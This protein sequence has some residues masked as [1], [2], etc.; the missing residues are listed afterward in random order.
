MKRKIFTLI[1]L[2]IRKICKKNITQRISLN[3]NSEFCPDANVFQ[4]L[5]ERVPHHDFVSNAK[6]CRN[7]RLGT[8][9]PRRRN[10]SLCL[11]SFFFLRLFKCFP[12]RLFDCFP[13]P[14]SFRVS[15]SIFLLRRVKIR[16]F[17]LIELL[18]VI[19]IIAILAAMLLPA[20]N[21]AKKKAQMIQCTSNLK[22]IGTTALAYT[23][24]YR[25]WLITVNGNAQYY[26][27]VFLR[28]ASWPI[29]LW[30]YRNHT[31]LPNASVKG[32][33]AFT[34]FTCPSSSSYWQTG[35]GWSSVNYALNMQCGIKWGSGLWGAVGLKL[36]GIKNPS[37]RLLFTEGGGTTAGGAYFW[38]S[39]D[40]PSRNWQVGFSHNDRKITNIAW[41]D[42]HVAPRMYSEIKINTAD[43][44][45]NFWKSDK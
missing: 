28:D 8:V 36:P 18:I 23:V 9:S 1:E 7:S 33:C 43:A 2:L 5:A 11:S 21:K 24:D 40:L 39:H 27:D 38:T 37:T 10:Q 31:E 15:C 30:Y 22:Q 20:L 13:V 6:S 19:A 34:D 35:R 17:T 26:P 25:D 12:V 29:V 32:G 3:L 41:M 14:S 4:G 16:I 44:D 42:G 45:N